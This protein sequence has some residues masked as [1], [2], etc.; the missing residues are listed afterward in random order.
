MVV[1][2]G[3]K[4]CFQGVVGNRGSILLYYYL[5]LA[6]DQ[7]HRYED[8]HME[9]VLIKILLKYWH[10]VKVIYIYYSITKI[11]LYISSTETAKN[12]EIQKVNKWGEPARC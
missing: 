5:F 3:E 7:Y 4:T 11:V 2:D 8:I 6:T 1:L 9:C 12:D 10:I